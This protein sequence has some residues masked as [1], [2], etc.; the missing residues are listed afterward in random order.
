MKSFL[1]VIGPDDPGM[2]LKSPPIKIGIASSP[3]DRM[4]SIQTG[5]PLKLTFYAL[6][7]FDLVADARRVER[8]C[9]RKFKDRRSFGEWFNVGCDEVVVY[10]SSIF[11][12]GRM[13][14]YQPH[15]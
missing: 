12:S 14:A 15:H 6:W 4:R 11:G 5:N 7:E 9:H 3:N 10:V 8:Y 2:E 1:Y 13:V